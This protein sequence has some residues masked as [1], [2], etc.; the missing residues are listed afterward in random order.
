MG[1]GNG[2]STTN[3]RDRKNP[4][5]FFGLLRLRRG[6][7]LAFQYLIRELP[8]G[9]DISIR[10]KNRHITL[11][12]SNG[13]ALT[14][15]DALANMLSGISLKGKSFLDIG[16]G[17]GGA[18]IFA[19]QLGCEMAVGI[20][21]EESLH[22][23]AEKNISILN[24]SAGCRSINADARVFD[25][26]AKFD[27]LYLFNPFNKDIYREV[28]ERIC[29]QITGAGGASL[30]YL[31]CYGDANVDSVN[32]S[33]LFRIVREDLCPYRGTLFRVY[34]TCH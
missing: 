14:T 10:S 28:V 1:L 5:D 15:K 29:E 18:V 33:G 21:Y 3:V 23:I 13:Y 2:Q 4:R 26:Y 8:R 32:A 7:H 31:I 11:P 30:K 24:V 9:L 16:S 12:G 25:Q 19:Y 20:E 34:E 6:L 27:V 17:K 22:R